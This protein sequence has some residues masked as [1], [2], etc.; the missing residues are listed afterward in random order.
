MRLKKWYG[1]DRSE[2]WNV[3]I[4]PEILN[5]AG[6]LTRDVPIRE[7]VAS[8]FV[9]TYHVENCR[10]VFSHLMRRKR[11]T[12]LLSILLLCTLNSLMFRG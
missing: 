2:L 12:A 3:L 7:S 8:V 6:V 4:K 11:M 9:I 10:V 5:G 1:P